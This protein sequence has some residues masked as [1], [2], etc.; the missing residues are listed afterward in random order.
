[1]VRNSS[2]GGQQT[3]IGQ[4]LGGACWAEAVFCYV[5][6][7]TNPHLVASGAGQVGL[8]GG[9]LAN[10]RQDSQQQL[11]FVRARWHCN[12]GIIGIYS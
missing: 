5:L 2:L 9:N 8:R 4:S 11:Y 6:Q 12:E 7:I 1:M 3:K 10:K